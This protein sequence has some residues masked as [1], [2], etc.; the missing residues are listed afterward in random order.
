MLL[1]TIEVRDVVTTMSLALAI[2]AMPAVGSG[3]SAPDPKSDSPASAT[4]P[5]RHLSGP[6]GQPAETSPR[7]AMPPDHLASVARE[8]EVARAKALLRSRI[9]SCRR[10]PQTCVQPQ[11]EAHAASA[12]AIAR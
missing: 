10:H 12:Q 1:S 7:R 2:F 3:Q 5:D 9:E 8:M 11:P 6:A 4:A